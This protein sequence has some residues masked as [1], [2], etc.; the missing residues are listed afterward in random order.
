MQ[1]TTRKNWFLSILSL[2]VTGG[3]LTQ[4][5]AALADA[6]EVTREQIIRE[7]VVVDFTA[8][9][10]AGYSEIMEGGFT[11]IQFRITSAEDDEPLRGVYPGV[12]IDLTQTPD[13]EDSGVGFDCRT[14]VTQYLQGLVG[15]RPM[16]DMNSY[17]VMVLN[18]DPSISVIDPVVG[19]TGITS[20]FANI[21]LK[22][23][24]ADWVKTADE[25]TMFVSMPRAG[26]VA[27]INLDTFK[28]THNVSAG[29]MPTRIALQPDEKYVWVGNNAER[30]QA[31]GVTVIDRATGA[32]V[33]SIETGAGHHEITFTADSRRAFVTNRDSGTVTVIDIPTLSKLTDLESGAMPISIAY[34]T[35][36][37]FVYVADGRAGLISVFDS[38]NF[39]VIR[40]IEVEEGLGPMRFSQDG[41]WGFVVNPIEDQVY[42]VDATTNDLAHAIDIEG[43]PFQVHVSRTF[44]YIRALDTEQVRMINLQELDRNG[45]VII[46]NFAAGTF[47]P[48]KAADVSIADTLAPAAQEAAMLVASPGD[49]TVYYYMEGMN[50]PMGAFRN[51]GHQ[52]RSVQIANRALKEVEPGLYSATV[53]LPV[54]GTFE[55]AFLNETPEFLHC[56][57]LDAANNPAIEKDRVRVAIAY[58]VEERGVPAGETV[59]IRFRLHNPTTGA[60][61]TGLDDVRVRS[62]RAPRFDLFETP[63]EHIG[64]GIYSAKVKL[65]RAGGYYVFVASPTLR[66]EFEDLNFLTLM[67]NPPER[68]LQAKEDGE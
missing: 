35:L 59:D 5:D 40:R 15:M 11:D 23:P 8:S 60:A 22:R 55:L 37:E 36:S 46:N 49:A 63:A 29:V 26:E 24:G 10:S 32:T 44:A 39:D 19:I 6:G 4:G 34:S 41:R 67:A 12:W 28:V 7:G 42:V 52:P 31:G 1:K 33:A 66:L 61:Y 25:K 53:K 58:L 20:L 47:P 57:T 54:A 64:D 45:Q 68:K 27:I 38:E 43:R 48:S 62:Y 14:R 16:I 13:G 56:F 21:D 17:Y 65:Q 50:A 9:P 30:D 51:Y 18:R 2:A 3:F